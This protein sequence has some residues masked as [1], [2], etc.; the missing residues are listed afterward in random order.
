MHCASKPESDRKQVKFE[1]H[2]QHTELQ[3][4]IRAGK[5]AASIHSIVARILPAM[6]KLPLKNRNGEQDSASLPNSSMLP[7]HD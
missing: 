7:N 3:A 1:K 2:G 4:G 6:L 5:S